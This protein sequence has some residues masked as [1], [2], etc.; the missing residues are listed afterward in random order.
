LPATT[1]M[2]CRTGEDVVELLLSTRTVPGG[3]V[4]EV[5][6]EVDIST[7]RHLRE[8]LARVA[9]TRP[10]VLIVDLGK[11]GFL[12]ST[13]LGMLIA[14]FKRVQADGGRLCLAAPQTPVRKLLRMTA[15]DRVIAV[16]DSV[17][18]AQANA[19]VR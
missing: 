6:G 14:T 9:D 10:A 1:I 11:V 7:E 15:L 16:Y 8:H 3:C 4:V 12:D 5:T 17:D 2:S 18:A 13:G 19:A